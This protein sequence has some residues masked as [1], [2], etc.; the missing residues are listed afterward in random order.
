[1]RLPFSQTGADTNI[2]ICVIADEEI[3]TTLQKIITPGNYSKSIMHFRL[4]SN[5]ESERMPLLGR[6][7]V[8]DEGVALLEEYISSL[9][10]NCN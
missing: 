4:S 7:V 1:M 8:H 3:S 5:D 9:T 10:Q 2:G 6:T